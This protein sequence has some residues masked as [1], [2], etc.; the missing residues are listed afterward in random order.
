MDRLTRKELK[1]DHF[2]EEVQHGIEYVESHRRQ[3]YRYGGIALAVL[4]VVGSV[5][6]FLR[7]QKQQRKDAFQQYLLAYEATVGPAPTGGAI[8]AFATQEEKD[9]AI[10][11]ALNNVIAKYAGSDEA[12]LSQYVLAARRAEEGKIPEA[13]QLLKEAS[14]AS[15]YDIASLGKFELANLYASEGKSADAEK[16]Y[17]ELMGKP[18]R[19][20]SKAQATLS[21]AAIVAEKNPQEAR[22]LVEPLRADRSAISRQ[23]VNFLSELEMKTRN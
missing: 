12:R 1:T 20:V 3:L 16:L 6:F 2:V 21:L 23:V 19:L 5:W 4:A 22:K 14:Q 15:D 10:A 8:K 18:S 17:R 11:A 13:E 9:K 7:W